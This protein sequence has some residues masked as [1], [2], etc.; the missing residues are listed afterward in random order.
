MG[1]ATKARH[2]GGAS[3]A[4]AGHRL[5]DTAHQ[6]SGAVSG[7][8]DRAPHGASS[9]AHQA[10][11]AVSGAKDR[12]SHAASSVV[13]QAQTMPQMTRE[14]AEGN[15]LAV[16]LIA[17]GVG[18]LASSLIPP[19]R[20]R[21][22]TR[23]AGETPGDAALRAAQAAGWPDGSPG[24]GQ[25]PPVSTTSR[26]ICDV[27]SGRER[28]RTPASGRRGRGC[29]QGAGTRKPRRLP[30][31]LAPKAAGKTERSASSTPPGGTIMTCAVMVTAEAT[32][33]RRAS[34]WTAGGPRGNNC[35][36]RNSGCPGR[37]AGGGWPPRGRHRIRRSTTG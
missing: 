15:P 10:S 36:P 25:P 37:R 1:I 21:A 32:A 6:A 17:L 27:D 16:S 22:A 26:E 20:G 18:W 12:A 2:D 31:T 9:V 35:P 30:L 14:R 7:A 13:H 28:I 5:S 33:I 29:V 24:A 11:G 8:K 4:E 23:P 34:R 19:S 3:A